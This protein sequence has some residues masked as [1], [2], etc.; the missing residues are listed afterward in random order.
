MSEMMCQ[1]E[2]N[3]RFISDKFEQAFD[4]GPGSYE[5]GIRER[6]KQDYRN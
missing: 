3:Y 5:D 6:T 2:G 4:M 1:Y